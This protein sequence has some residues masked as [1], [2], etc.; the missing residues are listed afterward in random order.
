MNLALFVLH[1]TVGGLI[2]AH[3][4]RKLFTRATSST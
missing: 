2:A 4:A 1:V 3:G